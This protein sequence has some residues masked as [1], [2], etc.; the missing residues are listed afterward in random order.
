MQTFKD[1]KDRNWGLRIDRAML[2]KVQAETGLLLT[3][4]WDDNAALLQQMTGDVL[5]LGDVL[6]V[7]VSKQAKERDVTKEDFEEATDGDVFETAVLS[8]I[9]AVVDF[10]PKARQKNL[11]KLIEAGKAEMEKMDERTDKMVTAFQ[12]QSDEVDR[13]LDEMIAKTKST[14]SKST[15]D[16]QESPESIPTQEPTPS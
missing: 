13:R 12:L 2:R 16:S 4:L 14:S 5:M 3:Q 9:E 6:W 8:L 10:F 11:R 1:S 7:V 15:T